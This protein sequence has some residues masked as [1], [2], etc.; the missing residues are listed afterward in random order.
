MIMD[1]FKNISNDVLDVV[2]MNLFQII[3]NEE[4]QN[5]YTDRSSKEHY[6]LLTHISNSFNDETFI[7]VGTLKGS[8]ALAL[9]TNKKN[10]VY[11]FNLSSQ[12]ELNYLPENVEFII[13]NVLNGKYDNILLSS[14]F[15]LL[16][17][18]HDGTFEKQFYDYIESIGY[19]GYLL[20]DDIHLNIEMEKFWGSISRKKDDLTPIGHSTGTGV[21]YFE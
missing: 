3:D 12:L 15:I 18:F 1:F 19:S 9:S 21:V 2:D 5:Y 13:D 16:D 11:S 10:K 6:R 17:T 20:L 7:D 4:Y 14:N 8:S